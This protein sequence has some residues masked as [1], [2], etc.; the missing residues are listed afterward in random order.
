MRGRLGR[1]GRDDAG[2][3]DHEERSR[4]RGRGR[5]RPAPAPA[6]SCPRPMSSAR[7]PP[8]PCSHRNASQRKPVE[9]VGPQRRDHADRVGRA[10]ARSRSR[11]AWAGVHPLA[12]PG[13]RR[14]R[15]RRARP[16]ARGRGR[17]PRTPSRSR[18]RGA[19]PAGVDQ[20]AQLR[21]TPGGRCAGAG[22]WAAR[23]RARPRVSAASTCGQRHLLAVDGDRTS[24]VEPVGAR[25]AGLG[26]RAADVEADLRG[27]YG[28]AEVG[29]VDLDD[30]DLVARR[31]APAAPLG[32]ASAT[33]AAHDRGGA[34]GRR[35]RL[36]C[37]RGRGWSRSRR[38]DALG[39]RS[40]APPRPVA[41]VSARSGCPWASS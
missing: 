36:A 32:Q 11:R 21:R 39:A 15:A 29:W 23:S 20:V 5:G 22:R 38:A 27:A 33:V 19:R 1:P 24:Q 6:G 8:S 3:G 35:R 7:I 37:R 4:R 12:R 13:R 9:L 41:A 18:G 34:S 31:A 10:A 28:L 17:R 14:C 16:R 40:R 26:R 2:R 30:L 25:R